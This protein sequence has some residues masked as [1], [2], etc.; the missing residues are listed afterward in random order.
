MDAT[1]LKARHPHMHDSIKRKM[2][3]LNELRR[4]GYIT[5]DEHATARENILLDMGFDIVPRTELP[6]RDRIAIVPRRRR[7]G[8][9]CLLWILLVVAAVGGAFA[10]PEE[11]LRSVPVLSKLLD[12]EPF[13]DARRAV[14]WFLDDLRGEPLSAPDPAPVSVPST[15]GAASHDASVETVAPVLSADETAAPVPSE[16][17]TGSSGD[18]ASEDDLP[19]ASL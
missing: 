3:D 16:D 4:L 17:V 7:R 8:C 5:E 14:T 12:V 9:G 1:I 13:V 15:M 19:P 2:E 11:T 10:V 18:V 6:D